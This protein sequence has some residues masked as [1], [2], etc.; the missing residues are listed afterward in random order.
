M[1][2]LLPQR[3]SQWTFNVQRSA[4]LEV[5]PFRV[6]IYHVIHSRS[7]RATGLIRSL[8][9]QHLGATLPNLRLLSS[10]AEGYPHGRDLQPTLSA[11][12][13]AQFSLLICLVKF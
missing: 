2:P 10:D 5:S 13:T 4:A 3:R 7:T 6:Q 12:S 1:V 9:I 8:L 11:T